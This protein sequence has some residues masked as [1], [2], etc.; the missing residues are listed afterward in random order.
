MCCILARQTPEFSLRAVRESA[1]KEGGAE[2]KSLLL[3][4][5]V[6]GDGLPAAIVDIPFEPGIDGRSTD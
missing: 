5:I 1:K 6:S 3:A 4:S 2:N